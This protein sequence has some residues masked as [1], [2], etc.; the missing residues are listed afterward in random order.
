MKSD[1]PWVPVVDVAGGGALALVRAA[2]EA[3]RAQIKDAERR[4]TRPGVR[5]ADHLSRRWLK[6][7][8]SPLQGEIAAVAAE[9]GQPGAFLLNLS[10]EWGCTA[11]VGPDPQGTG[12]RLLRTLD[13]PFDGLGRGLLGARM[14]GPAGRW[15]NLTWSGF[16]GVLT[17]L[18]PGRFAVAFNQPPMHARHFGPLALPMPLDWA[19]NRIAMAGRR[20]LP[21]AHLLRLICDDAPDYASARRRILETAV[22]A[23]YF[24]SLAGIGAGEGCVIE[25]DG[26]RGIA[27]EAPAAIANHWLTPHRPGHPR[28]GHSR[29]RLALI[30]AEVAQARGLGWLRAPILNDETRLVAELNPAAGLA[31][32]QGWE[33][34]GPATRP[35]L[36]EVD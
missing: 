31:L 15:L 4:F 3:A 32:V 9:V 16:A 13:W 34:D 12:M 7:S 27:H 22:A 11:A 14:E 10:Y 24:V 33:A 36:I 2:P 35:T 30:E 6:A 20:A 18:C 19:L 17:A 8:Q 29:E 21:P 1:L 5:L 28:T 26:E 23:P 25:H